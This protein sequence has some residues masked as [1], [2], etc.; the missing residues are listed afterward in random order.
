M[1]QVARATRRPSL[2][3]RA[4]PR[5]GHRAPLHPSSAQMGAQETDASLL[6]SRIRGFSGCKRIFGLF[7][8]GAFTTVPAAFLHLRAPRGPREQ[9][10]QANPEEENKALLL[11]AGRVGPALEN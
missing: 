2:G 8:P 6:P 4:A 7:C 9:Q 10:H 3:P 1:R 5:K 11:E